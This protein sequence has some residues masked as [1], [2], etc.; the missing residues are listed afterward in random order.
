MGQGVF[1]ILSVVGFGGVFWLYGVLDFWDF[2]MCILRFREGF[3]RVRYFWGI[4]I[5]VLFGLCV[6]SFVFG[7]L[8]R[9][10]RLGLRRLG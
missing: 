10:M 5:R 3:E 1:P 9:R 7:G 6:R 8:G 2:S 4:S